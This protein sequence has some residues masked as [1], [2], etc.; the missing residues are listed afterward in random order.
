MLVSVRFCSLLLVVF[1]FLLFFRPKEG[2]A[3]EQMGEVEDPGTPSAEEDMGQVDAE[4]MAFDAGEVSPTD[5]KTRG[6]R[7]KVGSAQE[8]MG[9][10][11][12]PLLVSD[13]FC[14]LLLVVCCFLLFFC[15]K[16]GRAQE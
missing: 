3:Q 4:A 9:E 7:K 10:V 2:R 6:A 16:K 15:P 14:C 1:C 5:K 11:E 13:R 12:D 8:E